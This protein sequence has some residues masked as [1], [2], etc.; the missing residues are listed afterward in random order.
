MLARPAIAD[1]DQATIPELR[2]TGEAARSWAEEIARLRA[3]LAD[4]NVRRVRAEGERDQLEV[5]LRQAL[6]RTHEEVARD[7][8]NIL[9]V[10]L[11]FGELLQ[12]RL[13]G[14]PDSLHMVG[15]IMA[16]GEQGK[17]LADALQRV[18]QPTDWLEDWTCNR[19]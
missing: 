6:G 9:S 16:A 17:Q 8:N 14:D 10:V 19:R 12:L 2:S 7:F 11:G 15:E 1:A 5:Q 3:E 18:G 4:Q 13:V